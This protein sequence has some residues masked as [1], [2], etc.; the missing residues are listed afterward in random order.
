ME[1]KEAPPELAECI[2]ELMEEQR[3]EH[4]GVGGRLG[5]THFHPATSVLIDTIIDGCIE[6]VRTE[7]FHSID[8]TP[9]LYLTAM[10]YVLGRTHERLVNLD[11]LYAERIR[12]SLESYH[13]CMKEMARERVSDEV[14]AKLG[15]FNMDA[16]IPD[17]ASHH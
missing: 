16:D 7:I 3:R 4:T 9:D 11:P 14:T 17:G 15:K 6:R 2:Q 1:L 10:V 13:N 8:M 5:H 12:E